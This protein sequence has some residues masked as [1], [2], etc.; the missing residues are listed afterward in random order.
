[1]VTPMMRQGEDTVYLVQSADA[2]RS[3]VTLLGLRDKT[4]E[5]LTSDNIRTIA[6]SGPAAGGDKTLQ[7]G[8]AGWTVTSAG[9][10]NPADE[11][12]ISMLLA[13]FTPLNTIKY[14]DDKIPT[15][16]PDITVSLT[17]HE[18]A[19]PITAPIHAPA[20]APAPG[21][22]GPTMQT[23]PPAFLLQ[24]IRQA[25]STDQG[26]DVSRTLRLFKSEVAATSPATAPDTAPA[27]VPATQPT[28]Q[29]KAVWD[30]QSPP[31]TFLAN[32]ALADLLT[33]NNFVLTSAYAT[34]RRHR[35]SLLPPDDA[36]ST[37]AKLPP[38]YRRDILKKKTPAVTRAFFIGYKH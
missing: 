26:K 22:V 1:M 30:T 11:M 17:V 36:M 34:G 28:T 31:W 10:A 3:V 21:A 29:W 27:T 25:F 4:I 19:V 9:K 7:R 8:V 32:T 35:K 2:D 24:N 13:S 20:T 23:D 37:A 14:V 12:K 15:G 18:A 16:T 6:V 33:H 38:D 5:R